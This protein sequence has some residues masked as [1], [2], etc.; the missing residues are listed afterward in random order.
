MALLLV[1]RRNVLQRVRGAVHAHSHEAGALD[2]GERLLVASLASLHHGRVD[3]ELG[4]GGKLEERFDDLLG[5]LPAHGLAALG[6]VRHAYGAV[7]KAQVVV[8]LRD[9]GDDGAGVAARRALLDCD[10]GRK[11]LDALHVGLLHLV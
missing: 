11:A 1:E 3:D 7:E 9:R 4:A 6:T 10:R 8:Y 5:R 2:V